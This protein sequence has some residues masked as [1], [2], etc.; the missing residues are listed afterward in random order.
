MTARGYATLA[1][2][3]LAIAL[4]G[5]NGGS[6]GS[7]VA[8]AAALSNVT[9]DYTGTLTDNA[10]GM[11]TASAIFSEHGSAVGG[12]LL[13]GPAGAT[14]IAL[15]MTLTASNTLAGSGTMDTTGA[16]CTFTFAATY[17]PNANTMTGTYAPVGTCTG[18]TG[19][20]YALTQQCMDA[21]SATRRRP[22]GLLAHC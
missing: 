14:S 13:L 19:G 21:A 22:N 9:G 17:D 15:A 11:Q 3:V 5:C 20:T 1:S 10:A 7:P 18:M 16:A 4:S 12:A 8:P 2:I 6:S